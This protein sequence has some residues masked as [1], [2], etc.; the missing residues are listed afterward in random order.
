MF[1]ATISTVENTF[2]VARML[3]FPT[4]NLFFGREIATSL[5]DTLPI[6]YPDSILEYH[7]EKKIY[8]PLPGDLCGFAVN[9]GLCMPIS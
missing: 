6:F 8:L 3:L 9:T 4:C 1:F 5:T 2:P 7:L